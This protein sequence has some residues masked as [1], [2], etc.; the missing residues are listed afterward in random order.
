MLMT[1]LAVIAWVS[2][3]ARLGG[4]SNER[5]TDLVWIVT[6]IPFAA[7]VVGAVI[8]SLILVARLPFRD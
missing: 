7:Y 5:G 6:G 4:F 8:Q 2:V 1:V 3:S